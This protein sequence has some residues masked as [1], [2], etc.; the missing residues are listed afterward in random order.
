[1]FCKMYSTPLM[2]D[3]QCPILIS[4]VH[5]FPALVFC[6]AQ[7]TPLFWC[8]LCS[9][10]SSSAVYAILV[11][12]TADSTPPLI[13]TVRRIRYSDRCSRCKGE[14]NEESLLR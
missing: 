12:H 3:M 14:F 9:V 2:W 11:L 6:G 5:I 10:L 13:C 4:G 1:L 7:C 8:G